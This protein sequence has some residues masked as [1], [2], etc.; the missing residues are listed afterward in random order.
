MNTIKKLVTLTIA[1]VT[2]TVF[3]PVIAQEKNSTSLSVHPSIINLSLSPG[4]TSNTILSI[5]NNGDLPLPVRLRFEPLVL[6]NSTPLQSIGSWISV[7]NSSLLIPAKKEAIVNIKIELPKTI[8][9]GGYYGMLYV[10]PFYSAGQ[11]KSGSLVLTK[12]GVLILG[13]VGVQDVPLNSIELQKPS[14]SSWVSETSTLN[15]SFNVK[16]TALNH[17]SAKPYLR[18]YPLFGK[19]EVIELDERLVFPGTERGWKTPFTVKVQLIFITTQ[20]FLCQ[21]VMDFLRKNRSLLLF[22]HYNSQ[23]F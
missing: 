16:N 19:T 9:L 22:S 2:L 23:L 15:L 21:L 14:L 6:E 4:K 7:S 10:E 13:S 20:I 12:M 18:I 11:S 5:T 1:I 17:I 3:S 8:P